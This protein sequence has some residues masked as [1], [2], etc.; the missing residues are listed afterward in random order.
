MRLDKYLTDTGKLTRSEAG[1]AIRN[2][3]VTVNGEVVRE[4]SAHIDENTAVV[5]LDGAKIEWRKFVYILLNKPTGVVSS[6]EKEGGLPTVLDLL[7]PEM[8]RMGL[9]PCGRLDADT[10]GFVLMT[11]D[12]ETA[13]N[14]LSPRHH[15]DKTYR[16]SCS[17]AI[18]EEIRQKLEQGVDI[19]DCVTL[20][21]EVVIT[22]EK[23]TVGEITLREGKY[24]Q[25]KRMFHVCGAEITSLERIRFA[26]LSLDPALAR[27]EWRYLTEEETAVLL[28]EE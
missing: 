13:H 2:R 23:Y 10:L 28:R 26:G 25:I 5:T 16:F 1:K 24:H 12:G 6:T 4:A 21:C 18:N 19:G 27:G 15:I 9:F 20:P 11:N 7:P 8:K 17:P 3:R 14:L 22:N